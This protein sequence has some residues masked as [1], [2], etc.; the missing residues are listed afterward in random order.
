LIQLGKQVSI[1]TIVLCGLIASSGLMSKFG[2]FIE[3]PFLSGFGFAGA[4][5]VVPGP[6]LAWLGL[7]GMANAETKQ[8]HLDAAEAA[9]LQLQLA[10]LER[11]SSQ[12]V[13]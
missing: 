11:S 10:K 4:T 12:M 9:L 1:G 2:A 5:F 3:V 7:N 6:F 8:A 13:T